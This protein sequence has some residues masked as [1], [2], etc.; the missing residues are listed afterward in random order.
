VTVIANSGSLAPWLVGQDAIAGTRTTASTC[1]SLAAGRPGPRLACGSSLALPA[2]PHPVRAR[3]PAPS[4]AP[5]KL[6]PWL[7]ARRPGGS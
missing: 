6:S 5:L 1:W 4:M 7:G 3:Q 2:S